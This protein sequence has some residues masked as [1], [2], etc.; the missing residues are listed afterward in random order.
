MYFFQKNQRK[1]IMILH[2]CLKI[3]IT[4]EIVLHI[5]KQ[6]NPHNYNEVILD[7]KIIKTI[8]LNKCEYFIYTHSKLLYGQLRAANRLNRRFV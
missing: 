3:V 8:T 6:V 5:E 1:L 2:A 7:L 4:L